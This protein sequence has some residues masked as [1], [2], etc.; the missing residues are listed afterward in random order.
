MRQVFGVEKQYWRLQYH[1]ELVAIK[2][3]SWGYFR[4]FFRN[5]SWSINVIRMFHSNTLE[6]LKLNVYHLLSCFSI[7]YFFSH[8]LFIFLSTNDKLVVWVPVVW[9]LGIPRKWKGILGFLGIPRPDSTAPNPPGP[10]QNP[11]GQWSSLHFEGAAGEG[12]GD[13]R[14]LWKFN[15]STKKTGKYCATIMENIEDYVDF[16]YFVVFLQ[17]LCENN[18]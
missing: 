2:R 13:T 15:S 4:T 17:I 12:G 18:L 5:I 1:P 7:F 10:G 6:I 16:Q 14:D 8:F 3:W 11:S 9:I